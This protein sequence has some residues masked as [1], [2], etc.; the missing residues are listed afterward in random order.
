M[1]ALPGYTVKPELFF[2]LLGPLRVDVGERQIRIKAGRQRTLLAALLLNANRVVSPGRLTELVWDGSP[3]PTAAYTIRTYVM[4]LRQTLGESAGNRIQTHS[5]G[6]LIEVSAAESDLH[7]FMKHRETADSLLA[8]GDLMGAG[9]ELHS[10]LSLWESPLVDVPSLLLRDEDLPYLSQLHWQTLLARFDTD[11]ELG[12]HDAIIPELWRIVRDDSTCEPAVALLMRALRHSG[13]RAD[14]LR[15]FQDTR[16]NLRRELGAEPGPEMRQIRRQISVTEPSGVPF[17][18]PPKVPNQQVTAESPAQLPAAPAGFTGRQQEKAQLIKLLDTGQE[19]PHTSVTVSLTGVSG[20][21]KSALGLHIANALR[22]AFP[23]GQ[24]YADMD[25]ISK[26]SAWGRSPHHRSSDTLTRFLKGLGAADDEIPDDRIRRVA[27][28]RT[29]L[30]DR[31]VLVMLDGATNASHIRH[32]LPGSGAS[33]AL[34]ISQSR[35]SGLD[36]VR[37]MRLKR[38]S[39]EASLAMLDAFLGPERTAAEPEAARRI[40]A[41]CAG[42]PMALRIVAARLMVRAGWTLADMAV[43]LTSEG[44]LFDELRD[45]EFSVKDTLEASYRAVQQDYTG[46]ASIM[47]EALRVI[48]DNSA[49]RINSKDFS[50]ELDRGLKE[51]ELLLDKLTDMWLLESPCPGVYLVNELVRAFSREFQT[52]VPSGAVYP[53]TPTGHRAGKAVGASMCLQLP[54]TS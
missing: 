46:D 14:A 48:A 49:S 44:R 35:L 20:V 5:P 7:R 11:I 41:A 36:S 53:L 1:F 6:Y 51:T 4:R 33:R 2:S 28:F 23:D 3:P 27:L 26:P 37:L 25:E 15:L 19:S 12:R 39:E 21:G 52:Q 50:V 42:F 38:L 29:L 17:P 32:L 30:A 16:L 31:K 8:Q 22:A 54:M 10:A 47:G 18:A 40:A 34:V 9:H 43:R 45:G 24:L 13:H